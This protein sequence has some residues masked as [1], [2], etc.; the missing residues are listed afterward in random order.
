[1]PRLN[2]MP[3]R[4]ILLSTLACLFAA[5]G[6]AFAAGPVTGRDVT[7]IA[8]GRQID[9]SVAI[10]PSGQR[11]V[12]A[13]DAD[14]GGGPSVEIWKSNVSAGVTWSNTA[15]PGVA[16][17]PAIAWSGGSKAYLATASPKTCA[18]HV[19][20]PITTR[21]YTPSTDALGAPDTLPT[22][23]T[24]SVQSWPRL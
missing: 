7:S 17:Q 14:A 15:V 9:P 21:S 22:L 19:D 13:T 2:P 12:A 5:P 11:L 23:A 10:A 6:L 18:D 8:P 4:A 20:V 1:V 24:P 3:R 16:T